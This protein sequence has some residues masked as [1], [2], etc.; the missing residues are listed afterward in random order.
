[1]KNL[2]DAIEKYGIDAIVLTGLGNDPWVELLKNCDHDP[3]DIEDMQKDL[4][5]GFV[6]IYINLEV[7]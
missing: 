4:D 3:K 5:K 1:M 6:K 7:L 2:R